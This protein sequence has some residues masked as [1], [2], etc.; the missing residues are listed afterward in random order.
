MSAQYY[1]VRAIAV[2][3]YDYGNGG[4]TTHP[5][6]PPL[7]HAVVEQYNKSNFDAS[8]HDIY[9]SSSTHKCELWEGREEGEERK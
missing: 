1:D 2:A 5:N 9:L 4:N 8:A 3:P 6:S 7:L